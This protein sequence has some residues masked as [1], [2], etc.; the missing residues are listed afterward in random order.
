[1]IL[2]VNDDG[3]RAPGL[4]ALYRALR[5]L[6]GLPVL[7]IAPGVEHS[8][9]AHAITIDRPL[10]VTPLYE[11]D[12]FGFAV[13]GTPSDCVKLGLQVLAP[14]RPRLVVSGI[15]DGPNVGRSLFYSGTVA[16]ALE[17]AIEGLPALAVSRDHVAESDPGWEDAAT[18]A[19]ALAL[20][21]LR[22]KALR[23]RVLNLNLP[24][25]PATDWGATLVLPHG[26][27]GFEERYRLVRGRGSRGG[28]QLDGRRV[29]RD[30][31]GDTDAHGLHRGQPVLSPLGPD[32]NAGDS[33][34]QAAAERLVLAT[35]PARSGT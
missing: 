32:L 14:V 20:R 27:S 28:W 23:G 9:Q 24:G 16:A 19:A 22:L 33:A 6:G 10:A 5:G 34:L 18:Y 13:D 11:E 17:G 25:T 2:L 7:A 30:D 35:R 4:R 15:N 3:I 12:F 21:C 29:E 26:R 8:G 1:M 31:E